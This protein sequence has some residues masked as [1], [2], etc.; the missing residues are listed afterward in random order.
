MTELKRLEISGIRSFKENPNDINKQSIDFDGPV[1]LITG[2]NGTGKTT[3]IEALKFATTGKCTEEM[4]TDPNIWGKDNIDSRVSLEFKSA[5]QNNYQIVLTPSI[6]KKETNKKGK[7]FERGECEVI[8]TTPEGHSKTTHINNSKDAEIQLPNYFGVSPPIIENVIFCHQKDSCWPIDCSTRDLKEK[9]DQIFGAEK[10]NG[11]I[12]ALK[13]T[14]KDLNEDVQKQNIEVARQNERQENYLKS[15]KKIRKLKQDI[16]EFDHDVNEK[17]MLFDQVQSQLNDYKK[18]QPAI[19]KINKEIQNIKG[20]LKSEENN[21]I[22][23]SRKIK[24]DEP[25][26]TCQSTLESITELINSKKEEQETKNRLLKESRSQQKSLESEKDNLKKE[27]DK[28]SEDLDS[29]KSEQTFYLQRMRQ[30]K[31]TYNSEDLDSTL[32]EKR[33]AYAQADKDLKDLDGNNLDTRDQEIRKKEI[34]LSEHKA[35][36]SEIEKNLENFDSQLSKISEV[37]EEKLNET[38]MNIK[39]A[40]EQLESFNNSENNP[41]FLSQ[42]IEKKTS[43]K[44]E[45][46]QQKQVLTIQEKKC[47]QNAD[48][49]NKIANADEQIK[50]ATE[51]IEFHLSKVREELNDQS[52]DQENARN[53]FEEKCSDLSNTIKELKRNRSNINNN[54]VSVSTNLQREESDFKAKED[55][56]Q[57]AKQ[58]IDNVLTE[59]EG[60]YQSALEFIEGCLNEENDKFSR[61]N[62]S[63]NVYSNFLKDAEICNTSG[64]HKCPLCYR[65]FTS[66]EEYQ[67]FKRDHLDNFISSLPKEIKKTQL[68]KKMYEDKLKNLKKIENDVKIYDNYQNNKDKWLTDINA[69]RE[70]EEK[71]SNELKVID[72]DIKTNEDALERLQKIAVNIDNLV[73][74]TAEEK[75]FSEIKIGLSASIDENLPPLKEIQNQIH[76]IDDK[77]DYLSNEITNL[78]IDQTKFTNEKNTLTNKIDSL[79]QEYETM[80]SDLA[81]KESLLR[82]AQRQKEEISTHLSSIE[83]LEAELDRLNSEFKSLKLNLDKEKEEKK[84]E[85]DMAQTEYNNC[86]DLVATIKQSQEKLRKSESGEMAEYHTKL[87]TELEAKEDEYKQLSDTIGKLNDECIELNNE[88]LQLKEKEENLT[89]LNQYYSVKDNCDR[90]NAELEKLEDEKARKLGGYNGINIDELTK[91]HNEYN[92]IL[93]EAETNKANAEE[94]LEEEEKYAKDYS[95]SRKLLSEAT[96]RL[97][98]IELARSDIQRYMKALDK[99]ILEYHSQKMAEINDTIQFLWSNTYFGQDID[100]IY[101]RCEEEKSKK[102][103]YNYRVVMKKNGIELDMDRRCSA[104]QKMLASIIIRL[105][106]AQTFALNCG[107]IALDEP[108]TNLDEPNRKNLASQ[109]IDLVDAQDSYGIN[110]NKKPFQLII[111]T[112]NR[113]FVQSLVEDGKINCFY[114]ITRAIDDSHHCSQ[115]QKCFET[116]LVIGH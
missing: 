35:K 63:E 68:N 110:N 101:I 86:K 15:E 116:N 33:M 60:S 81:N 30:F 111:I 57:V 90:L 112:H 51:R 2:E 85:R 8:T 14:L 113:E 16:I 62:N 97:K 61:L 82:K 96:I 13:S 20:E 7:S 17:Q 32:D 59:D 34:N 22:M 74:A 87:K 45:L 26:E 91:Q 11:A 108:T 71:L 83:Q 102:A 41:E 78:Y 1:T 104:G 105:A 99:T 12:K 24:S 64:H 28:I 98:S 44:N 40:Q 50:S 106:L 43:E 23:L 76:D 38:E 65:E 66:E 46:N 72:E 47:E 67:E 10:Y 6:K 93:A 53:I 115:I 58:N 29:A 77:I 21:K 25:K 54:L 55:E 4:I 27:C 84:N 36:V 94:K 42:M 49:Y 70:E 3:I 9:F 95:D 69:L 109:L 19:E 107:I 39:N 75:K 88:I 103:Q 92:R 48:N 31:E 114:Q 89:A 100:S 5:N 73:Q 79:S 52:I 56:A 37:S 80:K 18:V